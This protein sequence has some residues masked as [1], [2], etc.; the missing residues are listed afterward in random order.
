VF[1]SAFYA[2]SIV[3]DSE[4]PIITNEVT[5]TVGLVA[6]LALEQTA[7]PPAGDGS[8]SYKL[9]VRNTGPDKAPALQLG[10]ALPSGLRVVRISANQG[11]CTANLICRLGEIAPGAAVTVNV[12]LAAD[13][14]G[15]YNVPIQATSGAAEATLSDNQTVLTLERVA[16]PSFQIWL[17]LVNKP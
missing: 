1:H 5:N 10:G 2:Y 12:T 4:A 13:Q 11:S 16:D 3:F 6:A 7:E 9:T 8:R 14:P 17:P 15:S